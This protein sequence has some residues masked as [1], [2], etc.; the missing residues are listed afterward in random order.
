MSIAWQYQWPI[1]GRI[2]Q[3]TIPRSWDTGT[4]ADLHGV[5]EVQKD[6]SSYKV[7]SPFYGSHE[8]SDQ[9]GNSESVLQETRCARRRDKQSPLISLLYVSDS[10]LSLPALFTHGR[11][12]DL[13]AFETGDATE[14]IVFH[15]SRR[16]S[17]SHFFSNTCRHWRRRLPLFSRPQLHNGLLTKDLNQ[18][19]DISPSESGNMYFSHIVR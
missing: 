14:Q 16:Q 12:Q 4:S 7:E 19:N 2:P 18:L 17:W 15:P 8:A 1:P 5:A 3:V 10:Q 9:S 6:C 13:F 11:L